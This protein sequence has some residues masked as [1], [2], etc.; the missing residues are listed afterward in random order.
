MQLDITTEAVETGINRHL[1]RMMGL[2]ISSL[3]GVVVFFLAQVY[4]TVQSIDA[5]NRRFNTYIVKTE[6]QMAGFDKDL[7]SIRDDIR[8]LKQAQTAQAKLHADEWSEF[9]KDYGFFFN[10]T[11]RPAPNRNAKSK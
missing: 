11:A 3:L 8:G 6:A 1:V 7:A 9:W 2:V 10:V 5:D 4:T